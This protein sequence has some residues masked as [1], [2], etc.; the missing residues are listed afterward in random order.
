MIVIAEGC[1]CVGKTTFA[2]MLAEKTGYEVV[3]GSSF[4]IAE[5][6]Q[7]GM[8]EHM[9]KLLDRDNIIIDRFL[10]SNLV[11]GSIYNYP[12]MQ[13]IQYHSLVQKLNKTAIVIY[14]QAHQYVIAER[15]ATRGDDMIKVQDI[16]LILDSYNN[17][18]NGVFMPKTMLSL[19]T[20]DSDFNVATSMVKDMI[21]SDMLKTYIKATN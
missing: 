1:D 11:Y 12:M 20:T 17:N 16:N 8:Y 15:M 2:E 4:E 18:I 13:P 9:W 6:G 21:D 7:F 14:L 5:L 19:D 10:Y 3:K